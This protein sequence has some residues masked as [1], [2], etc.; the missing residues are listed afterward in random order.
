MFHKR[1]AASGGNLLKEMHGVGS[2]ESGVSNKKS[3]PETWIMKTIRQNILGL[4]ALFVALSAGAESTTTVED[5]GTAPLI[6]WNQAPATGTFWVQG[7]NGPALPYPCRP[8]HLA[9]ASIYAMGGDQ[10]VVDA[11]QVENFGLATTALASSAAPQ[12]FGPPVPAP[13]DK[14]LLVTSNKW[15][16]QIIISNHTYVSLNNATFDS[17]G[18]LIAHQFPSGVMYAVTSTNLTT[19]MA[20]WQP[21]GPTNAIG[22]FNFSLPYNPASTP[23]TFYSFCAQPDPN[24]NP[25]E[26]M[27]FTLMATNISI[28][29]DQGVTL[30]W[31]NSQPGN[32]DEFDAIVE[33]DTN[34]HSYLVGTATT[35]GATNAFS[36]ELT[37]ATNLQ[38]VNYALP[39]PITADQFFLTTSNFNEAD[40]ITV[41]YVI[42]TNSDRAIIEVAV[43]DVSDPS[44]PQFLGHVT[45]AGSDTGTLEIPG[46]SVSSGVVTLEFRAIDSGFGQTATDIT[47]TNSRLVSIVSP[48]FSLVP[49]GNNR[50]AASGG[51]Y[52]IG[53]EA[54]TTATNGTWIVNVYD[55]A[56]N[57]FESSSIAVTNIGQDI[58]YDDGSTVDSEY[59]D[60]YYDIQVTVNPPGS[61]PLVAQNNPPSPVETKTIRVHL[62]P[63]KPTAGSIVGYDLES[64]L[65]I[66][67]APIFLGIRLDWP[68]KKRMKM[69]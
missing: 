37:V 9:G 67:N 69:K 12:R 68:A 18:N 44:N 66:Q 53:F 64:V 36:F 27:P 13:A 49:D 19:P 51:G 1:N 38:F 34:G 8:Q 54:V 57:L 16:N 41:P 33:N 17:N 29:T 55:P 11:R 40:V 31:T 45:G 30:L 21:V 50:I 20:Q 2:R 43:Y 47:V 60:T 24:A 25:E 26:V 5:A 10:F 15:F 56:G 46:V 32:A 14:P 39:A 35:T 59:P 61:Q 58:I 22:N 3:K 62:L 48:V 42:N 52:G 7:P 4:T 6:P 65:K 28:L 63:P 23:N